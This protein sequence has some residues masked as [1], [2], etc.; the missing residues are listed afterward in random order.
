MIAKKRGKV[1]KMEKD[2]TLHDFQLRKQKQISHDLL[3]AF[4][5]RNLYFNN[6]N[7]HQTNE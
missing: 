4:F 1:K 6:R 5:L 2:R 3:L 7:H